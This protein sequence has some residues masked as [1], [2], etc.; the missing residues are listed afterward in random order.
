MESRAR[1]LPFTF[2]GFWL[3]KQE[4][5]RTT[6]PSKDEGRRLAASSN[7]HRRNRTS[8]PLGGNRKRPVRRRLVPLCRIALRRRSSRCIRYSRRHYMHRRWLVWF[9][10]RRATLP[11][12]RS[13]VLNLAL[14]FFN[15]TNLIRLRKGPVFFTYFCG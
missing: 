5:G 7:C 8:C 14:E 1:L 10:W 12:G 15:P 9:H 2:A 13:E 6:C 4:L 11:C 3:K